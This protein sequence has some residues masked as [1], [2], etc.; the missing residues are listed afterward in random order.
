[1]NPSPRVVR[2]AAA[3]PASQPHPAPPP[4]A[5]A[6][7]PSSQP[8][9][10]RREPPR[11]NNAG[12]L[13][14]SLQQA[15]RVTPT[16]QQRAPAARRLEALAS[17][18]VAPS[19]QQG[20]Q[21]GASPSPRQPLVGP[22]P[23]V[24]T[25]TRQGALASPALRLRTARQAFAQ[26]QGQAGGTLD[27]QM[28]AAAG[29]AEDPDA[30]EAALAVPAEQEEEEEVAVADALQEAPAVEAVQEG[31]QAEATLQVVGV[32]SDS[33]EAAAAVVPAPVVA[34]VAGDVDEAASPAVVA[35][36]GSGGSTRTR[37]RIRRR[38]GEGA[39]S[40]RGRR[41]PVR[42]PTDGSGRPVWLW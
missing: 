36:E 17:P 23:L 10:A 42:T 21:R 19:P 40:A 11:W 31:L 24:S 1:M 9:S 29:A 8:R 15:G 5:A 39:A 7:A 14:S 22:Q 2:A 16:H 6:E 41:T 20:Q 35:F 26:G 25:A 12:A 38:S 34:A 18:A 32:P 30:P 27:G 13:F 37:R 28:E 3:E 33:E 4:A